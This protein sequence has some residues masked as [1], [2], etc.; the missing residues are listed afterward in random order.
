MKKI[1]L[2]TLI[3]AILLMSASALAD[4][5]FKSVT[6]IVPYGAGGTTDLVGRQFAT[7]LGKVLGTTFVVE[8]QGGAS[9]SIGCQAALDADK[10]GSVVLF[11]AE[12]LGTQRVMDISK[13]SYADYSPI[14]AVANDPK[15][16]VVA[17]DSKYDSIDAL[18]EDIKANPG[19]IQMSYTGP[20]G[21]GHVQ[22]LI[23]NQYGY[24]PALTAYAGGSDCYIAVMSNQVV[25]TNSN[26]STV[27]SYIASGDLKLL[28]VA[29]TDRMSQYPDVPALS[30]KMENS[31]ALLSIP[32]TPLSLLVAKDVPQD[33]QEQLRTAALEAIK[34]PDFTAFIEE[35]NI[36]KLYEKYT[37]LDEINAFYTQ[38]E[39]TVSWLLYDAGAAVFSPETFGIAKP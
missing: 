4:Y 25:F 3:L 2:I 15:V 36:E 21:S 16:I 31:E 20:G 24:F 34:D 23:M 32:Y 13:L 18:L 7:A 37:T 11:T 1:C 22:A 17:G 14:I 8:N 6:M 30:E 5:P 33:I 38:W 9:G 27:A 12:S 19:T 10:D 39:S 35:N 28:A 26:Y 29:G